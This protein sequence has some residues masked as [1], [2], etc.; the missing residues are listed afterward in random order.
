METTLLFVGSC[1]ILIQHSNNSWPSR[2]YGIQVFRANWIS[3][4]TN[5]GTCIFYAFVSILQR[6]YPLWTTCV[7]IQIKFIELQLLHLYKLW[8]HVIYYVRYFIWVLCLPT[9]I[10][11]SLSRSTFIKAVGKLYILLDSQIIAVYA[12]FVH[13]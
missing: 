5:V 7:P 11:R 3:V 9:S 8:I 10:L 12:V 2:F 6:R 4:C 13:D 1:V